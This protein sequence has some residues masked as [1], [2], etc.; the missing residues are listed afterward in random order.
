MI[1][2]ND[3]IA[4]TRRDLTVGSVIRYALVV[5]AAA[6]V[7]L[8]GLTVGVIFFG[9]MLA[10]MALAYRTAIGTRLAADSPALIASGQYDEAER[11]IEQAVR[12]FV[13]S[14]A[15]KLTTLH[16]LAALRHAQRRWGESAE[17]CRA[18]LRFRPTAS[19]GGVLRN[20]RL[21]LA[22]A[23]LESG[24]VRGAHEAIAGLYTQR[25]ALTEAMNLLVVQ[26]DYESRVGVW[27]QMMQG[28]EG[29]IQ[30]A[31]LLPAERSARAQ[32][33]L[34][35][36]AQRTGRADLAHFLRRRA[37]LLTDVAELTAR[38]PVLSELWPGRGKE[39]ECPAEAGTKKS[40]EAAAP[41]GPQADA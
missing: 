30:M 15:A 19:L 7:L 8:T 35:L 25:L 39:V 23:L 37:E 3:A 34:A 24:D 9:L 18:I 20:S 27:E 33:M 2:A 21:I 16:H 28:V 13:P 6:A 41:G 11:R 17:L 29:K 22:D 12:S 26:L 10:W 38:R 36:A 4:R 14:R 40:E 32:G 31:E 5:I 1:A